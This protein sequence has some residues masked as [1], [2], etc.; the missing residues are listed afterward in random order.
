MPNA[1]LLENLFQGL[2]DKN[3]QKMASCYHAD[4]KFQ[5]IAFKLDGKKQIHAMWHMIAESDLRATFNILN[6]DD[7]V[8][9]VDLIVDYTFRD[10]GRPVHNEIQSNFRFLDNLIIEHH[11][12]CDAR[13]WGLQALGP[14]KGLIS[15]LIPTTRR[16]KASEI[17]DKFIDEHPEYA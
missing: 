1:V 4:T 13:K 12:L 5:D 11:D 2:K 10:T 15:W 3:H 16:K 9:T 17:I 7:K 6:V 8:G 14:I